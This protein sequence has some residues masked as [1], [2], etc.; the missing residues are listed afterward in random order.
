M[1]IYLNLVI[2]EFKI[3]SSE[4]RL[5]RI[6]ILGHALTSNEDG[7]RVAAVIGLVHLANLDRVVD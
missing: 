6:A 7:K 5:G 3:N 2:A 4:V 1:N